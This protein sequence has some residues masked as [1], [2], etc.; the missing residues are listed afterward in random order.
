[1]PPNRRSPSSYDEIVRKTV[2]DPDSSWRPDPEQVRA[3]HAGARALDAEERAL[4]DRVSG[5]LLDDEELA[6]WDIDVEIERATVR[7]HGQVGDIAILER[8]GGIVAR[9]DG[10][11]EVVN[12][13]VVAPPEELRG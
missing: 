13:L 8:I 5:A 3:A 1:M 11:G 10:V 6:A 4:L 7:L 12:K 9:V 2:P